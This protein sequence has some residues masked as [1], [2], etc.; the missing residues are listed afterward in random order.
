[1]AAPAPCGLPAN[2]TQLAAKSNAPG[3]GFRVSAPASE[4]SRL[5]SEE[6]PYLLPDVGRSL[7]VAYVLWFVWGLLGVHKFYLGR[8]VWGFVYILTGGLLGVGWLVDLFTLPW[9]VRRFRMRW[10]TA[11]ATA[12][13]ADAEARRPRRWRWW[14]LRSRRAEREAVMLD[15]LRQARDHGGVLSVTE[16]VLATGRPYAEVDAALRRMQASGFVDVRNHPESGVVQ[17]VFPELI[18]GSRPDAGSP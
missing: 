11:L 8:P 14:P 5:V 2:L 13:D 6:W 16:G 10:L 9:Q 3:R 15:L 7:I 12:P 17:Y 1:M 18:R 4:M